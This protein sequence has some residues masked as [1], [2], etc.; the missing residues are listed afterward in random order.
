M[1]ENSLARQ[2]GS[3]RMQGKGLAGQTHEESKYGT[4]QMPVYIDPLVSPRYRY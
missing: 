4:L 2:Y 3:R 1:T